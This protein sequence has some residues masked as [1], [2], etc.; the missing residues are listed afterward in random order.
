MMNDIQ[1]NIERSRIKHSS[2]NWKGI[3]DIIFVLDII[4]PIIFYTVYMRMVEFIAYC[5]TIPME[6]DVSRN[7]SHA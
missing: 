4:K 2:A 7:G 1:M 6:Y 3:Y 5:N